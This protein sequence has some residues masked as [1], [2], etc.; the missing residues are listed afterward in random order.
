MSSM[1]PLG[2]LPVMVRCPACSAVIRARAVGAVPPGEYAALTCPSCDAD[3][4][5]RPGRDNVEVHV[6]DADEQR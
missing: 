1:P 2:H 5:F 3:L 6:A 4:R